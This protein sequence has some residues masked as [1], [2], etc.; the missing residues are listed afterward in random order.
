MSRKKSR[1]SI[2]GHCTEGC[3]S[4][5]VY[6][7]L[8]DNNDPNGDADLVIEVDGLDGFSF[9]HPDYVRIGDIV[10]HNDIALIPLPEPLPINRKRKG[11]GSSDAF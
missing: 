5:D 10:A 6:A 8:H 4:F 11:Y 3:L 7:G 1:T 9:Q 2:A